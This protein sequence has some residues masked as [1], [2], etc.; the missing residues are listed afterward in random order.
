MS[1]EKIYFNNEALY[2]TFGIIDKDYENTENIKKSGLQN[3]VV[4]LKRYSL[5]NF[6]FDPFILC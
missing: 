3:N 5:E 1:K 4:M 6:I 2:K